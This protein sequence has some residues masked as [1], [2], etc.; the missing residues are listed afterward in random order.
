[1]KPAPPDP[2]T[3]VRVYEIE[4]GALYRLGWHQVPGPEFSA[5]MGIGEI[6]HDGSNAPVEEKKRLVII[7]AGVRRLRERGC[8]V[9][10]LPLEDFEK[11]SRAGKRARAARK[12]EAARLSEYYDDQYRLAVV[13]FESPLVGLPFHEVSPGDFHGDL[14]EFVRIENSR[15]GSTDFRVYRLDHK[16]NVFILCHEGKERVTWASGA[17]APPSFVG[18]FN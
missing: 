16:G 6:Y 18:R 13:D 9:K 11:D 12:K 5:L 2:G 8:R 14:M 10:V 17:P 7:R 4:P 15:D 3:L 1:M